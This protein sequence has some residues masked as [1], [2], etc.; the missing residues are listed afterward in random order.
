MVRRLLF[1]MILLLLSGTAFLAW[2]AQA[3]THRARA[4]AHLQPL[5]SPKQQATHRLSA[6]AATARKLAAPQV[7]PP[8]MTGCTT[9]SFAPATNFAAGDGA[10][11]VTVGDFNGDGRLDLAI[12]DANSNNVSV[13]LGNGL[14]GFGAPTNFAAGNGP[15]SVAV[16][17]FNGDGRLD[18]AVANGFSD[19]VSIL[20]GNGMGGFGAPTNF[21]AGDGPYSVTTGDFNGDGRL[22]LA[23]ANVTSDNVSVLLGN[24]M[25]GF[26][27]PTN[28]AAGDGPVSVTTGDFNG[29]GRLDLAVANQNSDNVSVL[30]NNCTSNSPPTITPVAVA[31]TEGAPASNSQI[32]TVTDTEDALNTLQIQISSDGMTFSNTATLNGVTVTLTDSNAGATGTNPNALGQVFADVVAACAATN[33]TFTLKVTD[34]GGLMD[35]KPFMVTVNPQPT[36]SISI[37]DVTANEGNAGTTA[38]T[39]KVNLSMANTCRIITVQYAT[40]DGTATLA[41]NDYQTNAG[42]L[43]FNPGETQKM[44]MVLVNG[45]LNVEPNE[46]FFVN[47]SNPVN[48]TIAD[49]Q[50]QGTITNDDLPPF[51]SLLTDP[52]VCNGLGS[53]VTVTTKL[54]NPNNTPQAATI[55]VTLPPQLTVVAGSCTTTN[56]TCTTTPPNQVAYMGTLAAGETV[57]IQYQARV[58]DGTPDGTVITI[59]STGTVNGVATN[60]VAMGTVS[61]PT[62]RVRVSDQK[63]GSVLVFPFYTS[64][65]ATKSD[66]RLQLSNIGAAQTYL[67]VFLLDGATCQPSDF[68]VCLTPNA[69]LAFKASEYDPEVTGWVLAVAVDAQGIPIRNNALIGN[70]FVNDGEYVDNYG[71]ESFGASSTSV[72]QVVNNTAILRFDGGGY[73]PVPNQFAVEIQSPLDSVGQKIV[74]VGLQGDL[75]ASQLR[76]AGQIGTGT[77]INGNE[78]PI[79]SFVNFLLGNCQ[80]T[81]LITFNQPRVPSGMNGVIPK[82]QV[83]TMQFRIGGGVGLL[84][85]PRT[86]ANRWSGIRT[87]HKVGSTF[88]TLTI[89][90]FV[91]VC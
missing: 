78:K 63:P 90:V 77:V 62:G 88:T 14:G 3:T 38:F 18:L 60:S 39:F 61:C 66:T 5:S 43:T 40:A 64:R 73:D 71:A 46:T 33:A 89:P 65:A 76:G 21:A 7:M 12:A 51:T 6:T 54:T 59:S 68:F 85:S 35:T 29:D 75:T 84:M 74:T 13:L 15:R 44:V 80:A 79:A 57:T 32:A 58:A 49:N 24:G 72:A 48:A 2:R 30:L 16:G 86:S 42:T 8:A 52:F 25:G 81:A 82:G 56:G 83:G 69:S 1:L 55:N 53:V 20:L 37:T 9:P 31:R 45:D 19:N 34:S 87:L 41:D 10:F 70:A 47:L 11:S 23:V 91:P 28:F 17:D 67:H 36:P 4:A 50:G 26:G 27:A 22:D